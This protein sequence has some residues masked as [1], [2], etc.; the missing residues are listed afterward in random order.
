MGV[1][2]GGEE[3]GVALAGSFPRSSVAGLAH[4]SHDAA[5]GVAD[6][7]P[8]CPLGSYSCS[9]ELLF[10]SVCYSSSRL[11][12]LGVAHLFCCAAWLSRALAPAKQCCSAQERGESYARSQVCKGKEGAWHACCS[13]VSQHTANA[14]AASERR[15]GSAQGADR[16]NVYPCVGC[17]GSH[18][19]AC[20]QCAHP[21]LASCGWMLTEQQS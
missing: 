16:A 10:C 1:G 6:R 7:V 20:A 8:W 12:K 9:L 2:G 11:G 18:G 15:A 19:A 5:W 17:H 3:G 4:D 14:S 21:L 13:Q